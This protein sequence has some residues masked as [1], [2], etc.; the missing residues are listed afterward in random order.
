MVQM[1]IAYKG[2]LHCTA[3]HG[4]SG[5][6]IDTDAP[7]DNMGRGEAFSP[8]DL[9]ATSLATCMV[10]TMGISAQRHNINIEGT[11]ASVTKEMVLAPL[12][13]IGRLSVTI[14]IPPE[15]S[16]DDRHRMR[17][18]AMSCPVH[19]SLHPDV[20]IPVTFYWGKQRKEER[21]G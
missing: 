7:K 5:T 9:L 19:K 14:T 8:T 2:Q 12:R 10:T 1:D 4:P 18:A 13:R 20:Q 17:N 3:R 16:E 11:T 21:V 6:V 15:L